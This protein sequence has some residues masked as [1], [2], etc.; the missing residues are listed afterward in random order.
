MEQVDLRTQ[1]NNALTLDSADGAGFTGGTIRIRG[2]AGDSVASSDAD[3]ILV[4]TET[5]GG[6]DVT[7]FEK[8]GTTLLVDVG[9]DTTG[10]QLLIVDYDL[11][12]GGAEALDVDAATAGAAP[13]GELRIQGDADDAVTTSD[14]NWVAGGQVLLDG[15]LVNRFV[16]GTATLLV[17]AVVDTSGIQTVP[18]FGAD[19][20]GRQVI[21]L[22][23]LPGDRGFIIQ[24]DAP[25]DAAGYS[26]SSA[27]DINGDGYGDLIVGARA[28]DDGGDLA[29]AA[30]VVFGTNSG[31]GVD[32]GGR[33]VIDLDT[34]SAAQGFVIQGDANTDF[35][36]WSVSSAGDV[37][38]DGYDDL[39]V[40]APRGDDGGADAGEAY[41]L[42]GGA[43][44]FG[45][46]VGGRQVIDLTGLSAAQGFVIQGDLGA[47]STGYSVSSAGDVNGDGLMDLIVGAPGGISA[48]GQTFVLFGTTGS[49]GVDVGGRQVI[50]LTTLSAAQ[51]FIV[52][53]DAAGDR[54]GERV[55][56][57]GDVNGDGYDDLIIGTPAGDDG[58]T[59]SGEA[60]VLF[61]TGAGFGSDVGGRQVLGLTTL[62]A[63][64]GFII[65]GDAA[66][67]ATGYSVSSAGDINGDGLADLVVGALLGDDGGDLAGEAYVVFGTTAGFGTD[68]G[69]RQVLDLTTLSAAEG[70]IIQGDAALDYAGYSVSAAGDINGDGIGDLIVSARGEDGGTYAGE[71]YVLFGTTAGFGVDV[72]GRQVVD[73]T[74]LSAAEGFVIQGDEAYDYAGHSVSAAGDINGDGFADIIVGAPD[75]DDGAEDAGEGYVIF[76]GPAGFDLPQI[77][78]D[79]GANSLSGTTASERFIGGGGDDILGDSAIG[80]DTLTGGADVFLGGAGN[81]F[82]DIGIGSFFRVDGGTGSDT[83]KTLADLDLTQLDDVMIKGI[84]VIEMTN[85]GGARTLTMDALDVLGFEA[86]NQNVLGTTND[87]VLIV[88]GESDDTLALTG[89]GAATSTVSFGGI[90]YD[91]YEIDGKVVLAVD[92]EFT[93][94]GVTPA[95]PYDLS[96]GGPARSRSTWPKPPQR[97]MASCASRAMPTMP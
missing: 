93:V 12:G 41:V 10:I 56:S 19:V 58:G 40:G 14:A 87:N 46:D 33:Q 13:N 15:V 55:S 5:V 82:I 2:D 4:G 90:D 18:V 77:V 39:I 6:V 26:V 45:S 70:F 32:V 35:A 65:Q 52:T 73:L 92:T 36:G 24:G 91:L 3:W 53:G 60:Y 64:E 72:G 9:V 79:G 16:N 50:D 17:D 63:A 75:G 86:S 7:R 85:N 23:S 81:D 96:G 62:S 25:N 76:G 88:R 11:R 97:P 48:P 69:G 38:G 28:N 43:G 1:G 57:A 21:D 49:F 67:D 30:Y 29:G 66:G 20:A 83:L 80:G 51:G 27:G 22:T 74:T 59:G 95:D 8:D 42:F 89:F 44:T 54:S 71:A 68:V 61:G 94:T 37:N 84:E 78:G 31:F 34:L 47:D